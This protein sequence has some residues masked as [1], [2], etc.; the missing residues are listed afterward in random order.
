MI[1]II[2]YHVNMEEQIFLKIL[3]QLKE[4]FIRHNLTHGGW[5]IKKGEI[6]EIN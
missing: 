4:Q 1:Y 2:F 5:G 3:Y 6:Y